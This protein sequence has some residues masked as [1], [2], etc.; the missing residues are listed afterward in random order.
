[1]VAR[2][3]L[4]VTLNVDCL[5]CYLGPTEIQSTDRPARIESVHQLR[6]SGCQFTPRRLENSCRRFGGT[7]YLTSISP[8]RMSKSVTSQQRVTPRGLESP[9][10]LMWK[11]LLPFVLYLYSFKWMIPVAQLACHCNRTKY[12]CCYENSSLLPSKRDSEIPSQ[13]CPLP[14]L[15]NTPRDNLR[16]RH[17]VN[18]ALG[19]FTAEC[20]SPGH[21]R[22]PVIFHIRNAQ[23]FLSVSRTILY[24]GR[25]PHT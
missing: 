16:T 15:N 21:T 5:L 24:K 19:T 6:Y 3:R 23:C 1:M 18:Q 14:G 4:N 2:T 22:K 7:K 10:V 13:C 8:C 9:S 20:T 12:T 17:T 25:E 11:P